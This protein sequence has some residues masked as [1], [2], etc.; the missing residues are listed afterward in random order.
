[1]DEPSSKKVVDLAH[2]VARR[3]LEASVRDEYRLTVYQPA[4][5]IKN[6]PTMLRS[7]R[8][9]RVK[10]GSVKPIPDL[11]IRVGLDLLEVWSSDHKGLVELD[12]WFQKHG[13]ETSGIW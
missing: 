8:D 13:C 11:G 10:M 9:G 7:F 5:P 2:K 3:W 12:A 6:L 4:S 1:V